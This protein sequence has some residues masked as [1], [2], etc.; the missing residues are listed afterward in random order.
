MYYIGKEK[1]FLK[2]I[3]DKKQKIVVFGAGVLGNRLL[4]IAEETGIK[5][6]YVCDNAPEKQHTQIRN[7]LYVI[8]FSRIIGYGRRS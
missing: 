4:D 7:H 3:W 1:D 6:A 5:I 2:S 8:F